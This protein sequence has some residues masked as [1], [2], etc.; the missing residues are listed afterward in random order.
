[1][2]RARTS[3]SCRP[4]PRRKP[5]P[6]L[7]RGILN[8]THMDDSAQYQAG[9][10]SG[11]ITAPAE[12]PLPESPSTLQTAGLDSAAVFDGQEFL[13]A[14]TAEPPRVVEVVEPPRESIWRR[15]GREVL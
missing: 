14:L 13:P 7:S 8:T 6:P 11:E 10:P 2:I 3:S 1:M 12:D 9:Q 15:A 5:P 4:R